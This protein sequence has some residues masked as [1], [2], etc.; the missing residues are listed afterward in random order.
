MLE[1]TDIPLFLDG[2]PLVVAINALMNAVKSVSQ[3]VNNKKKAVS[4]ELKEVMLKS[5][6]LGMMA[7]LTLLLNTWCVGKGGYT[8]IC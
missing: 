4:V 1:K 2:Y 6:W 7:A 8:V 3:V 5:S